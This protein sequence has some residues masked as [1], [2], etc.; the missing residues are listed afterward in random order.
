MPSTA[1]TP[2]PDRRLRLLRLHPHVQRRHPR[3]VRPGRLRHDGGGDALTRRGRRCVSG[4]QHP[5]DWAGAS[6]RCLLAIAPVVKHPASPAALRVQM[7]RRL[8]K[9]NHSPRSG[10]RSRLSSQAS[11]ND[12]PRVQMSVEMVT[13]Q[14]R[15]DRFQ[16][17][18]T[19]CKST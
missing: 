13:L 6:P 15:S 19:G 3:P 14:P 18:V 1:P 9:K 5:D 17:K 10:Q 16:P 2:R 8:E 7:A 12:R 4:P 11:G